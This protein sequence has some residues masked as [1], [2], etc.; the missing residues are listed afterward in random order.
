MNNSKKY[1]FCLKQ[2]YMQDNS[3]EKRQHDIHACSGGE[4]DLLFPIEYGDRIGEMGIYYKLR[5]AVKESGLE[6]DSPNIIR[7]TFIAH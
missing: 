6:Y 3:M 1:N 7:R 4:T 5:T 2:G